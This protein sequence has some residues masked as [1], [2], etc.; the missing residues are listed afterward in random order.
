MAEEDAVAL[1]DPVC[2]TERVGDGVKSGGEGEA[3]ALEEEVMQALAVAQGRG[4]SVA[5]AVP[6]AAGVAEATGERF[7]SAVPL[8]SAEWEAALEAVPFTAAEGEAEREVLPVLGGEGLAVLV[9]HSVALPTLDSEAVEEG[10]C[11]LLAVAVA[12]AEEESTAEPVAPDEA[13]GVEEALT[14][15]V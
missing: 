5:D 2:T 13:V 6:E 1:T 8:L 7:E 14:V 15:A 3:E 11:A 9:A 10:L 12:E 4:E